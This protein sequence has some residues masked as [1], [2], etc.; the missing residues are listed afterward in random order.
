MLTIANTLAAKKA[1]VTTK[2]TKAV[3]AMIATVDSSDDVMSAA[4]A[5]LPQSPGG[6]SS[7][8]DEDADISH[9][10]VSAPLHV[11]HLFW[12][13]QIHGLINDFPVKTRALIDN[14]MHLV[15]IRPDLAAELGLK[16]YHLHVPEV[17]DV[18]LKNTDTKIRCELS[19]FIKLSLT[20]LDSQWTSQTVK[21]I[22]APGLCA[23]VILGLPFLQHNSIVTDHAS[24]TCIDKN[25]TMTF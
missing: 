7:D 17:V 19:E 25:Q 10:N 14:G 9:R 1:K 11:K 20:S 15:L 24:C 3:S 23:P 8:S 4:A 21:A 2:T 5:V 18:A 13:C 6:F 16:K 12:N 22:I